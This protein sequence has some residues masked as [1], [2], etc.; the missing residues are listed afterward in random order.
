MKKRDSTGTPYAEWAREIQ[1]SSDVAFNHLFRALYEPLVRFAMKYTRSKATA[2]DIVQ[3][4]FVQ[5][6]QQ[7]SEI[8]PEQSIRSWLYTSVRNRSLN[9]LRDH[10][11]ESVGLNPEP[12]MPLSDEEN[13]NDRVHRQQ[14]S[15]LQDWIGMLPDRQKEAF[16]LSR[17]EG[18]D[19]EEISHVMKISVRTVNNHIVGALQT[20]RE[21]GQ[22]SSY[23]SES[24]HYE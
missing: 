19:H 7:R 10:Q 15:Q 5:L 11:R 17:L 8:N 4:I 6:W 3:D 13:T 2:C 1:H 12:V 16:S 21:K 9:H 20:L 22:Y 24:V 23:P 14:W 18:L